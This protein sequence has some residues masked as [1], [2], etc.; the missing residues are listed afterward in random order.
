[1]QAYNND[2]EF[3][4]NLVDMSEAHMQADEFIQGEY[5]QIESI[6]QVCRES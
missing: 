6:E 2:I 4:K 5:G 1:M 3:K